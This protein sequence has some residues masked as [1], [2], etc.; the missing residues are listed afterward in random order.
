MDRKKVEAALFVAKK[1]MSLEEIAKIVNEDE[2]IVMRWLF[3]LKDEYAERGMVI[4]QVA[5][6]FEMV[7]SPLC[8]EVVQQIVPKE[9]ESLSRSAKETLAIVAY[10]QPC[11]RSKIAKLRGVLNPD[12]GLL[13]LLDR[14]LIDETDDGFITTNEFLHYYGI[15]DLK[16]LPK[17]VVDEDNPNNPEEYGDPVEGSELN[18]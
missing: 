15:N 5:G 13:S 18:E 17:I 14:N 12:H 7:S 16:E 4:K 10:K 8:A 11:K 2:K 9:Y 6:G 3:E 1:P